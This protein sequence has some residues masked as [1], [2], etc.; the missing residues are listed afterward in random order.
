MMR[1]WRIIPLMKPLPPITV[2]GGPAEPGGHDVRREAWLCFIGGIFF[3]GDILD[4]VGQATGFGL[5]VEWSKVVVGPALLFTG[6]W[7][8]LRLYRRKKQGGPLPK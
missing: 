4:G 3:T 6:G 2:P 8:L 1:L 5:L 7:E